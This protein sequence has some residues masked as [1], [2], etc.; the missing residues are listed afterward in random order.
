[1]P[2]NIHILPRYPPNPPITV[3][4]LCVSLITCSTYL[5]MTEKRIPYTNT[6]C[7]CHAYKTH[8][9]YD[10]FSN[11]NSDS[12]VGKTVS[13]SAMTL[14]YTDGFR[15]S[16]RKMNMRVLDL[17]LESVDYWKICRM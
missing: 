6:T 3:C 4:T 14:A 9:N 7:A 12:A 13:I 5:C 15:Q 10:K 2:Q 1:M 11:V 8:L 16:S 17:V